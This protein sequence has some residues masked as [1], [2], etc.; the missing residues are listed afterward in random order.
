MVQEGNVWTGAMMS[1]GASVFSRGEEPS[2][3]QIADMLTTVEKS[4][5]AYPYDQYKQYPSKNKDAWEG[6]LISRLKGFLGDSEWTFFF[7]TTSSRPNLIGCG[8]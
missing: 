8:I 5:P 4:P 2:E 6:F 1:T 7:E 3:R